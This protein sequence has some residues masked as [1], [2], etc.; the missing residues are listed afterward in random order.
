MFS[1][2]P[3]GLKASR[4]SPTYVKLARYPGILT[5]NLH[6]VPCFLCPSPVFSPYVIEPPN[7]ASQ[8]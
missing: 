1:M 3:A 5:N 6:L 7:Q 4:P 2:S 8:I